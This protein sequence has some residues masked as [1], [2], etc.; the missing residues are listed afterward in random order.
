[1]PT[2][3]FKPKIKRTIGQFLLS[4]PWRFERMKKLDPEIEIVK[5]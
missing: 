4:L 5:I 3:V 2:E 1:M